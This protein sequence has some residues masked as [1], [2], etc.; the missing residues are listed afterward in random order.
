M[1]RS[2]LRKKIL[3]GHGIVIFNHGFEKRGRGRGPDL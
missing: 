2:S 1:L 3:K